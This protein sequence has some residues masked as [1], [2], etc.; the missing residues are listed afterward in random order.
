MVTEYKFNGKEK[1]EETGLYYYG[2]RYYTP[3]LSIWLSVDPLSDERPNLSPFSYCQNNPVILIDPTGALDELVITGPEADAATKNLQKS[4][5]LTLSRDSKTGIVTATGNPTTADDQKLLDVI[6]SPN[7]TVTVDA[8]NSKEVVYN[9]ESYPFEGGAFMGNTV[10]ENTTTAKMKTPF[11][12]TEF[13]YNYYTV[14][15]NQT[16]NPNM[17][18]A[19]DDYAGTPGKA[20]EH[21]VT[22]AYSGAII[23]QKA[24]ISAGPGI[25][26]DNTKSW[27][28]K[29]AHNAKTTVP[30]PGDGKI[31]QRDLERMRI[32][33]LK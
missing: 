10:Y 30:Q 18:E 11:G 26:K 27:I 21:E 20:M 6:T 9:G 4:T 16:V 32:L 1:D 25:V 3:D 22:E 19:F 12:I 14:D 33:K 24:G 17:L 28:G 29:E 15:A 13:S 8:I 5:S 31:T 7:I 23:S 2:A